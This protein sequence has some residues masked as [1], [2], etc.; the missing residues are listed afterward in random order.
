[1]A[2]PRDPRVTD[3]RRYRRERERARRAPAPRKPRSEESLLGA[4]PRAGLILLLAV[5][6]LAVMAYLQMRR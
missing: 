4:R 2:A 6:V 5:V 1:M 3:L